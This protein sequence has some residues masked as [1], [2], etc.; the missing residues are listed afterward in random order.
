[1]N[2]RYW[3]SETVKIIKSLFHYSGSIQAK[4]FITFS[5]VLLLSIT[6]ISINIY[7]RF[8]ETIEQNAVTYVSDSIIHAN[9]NFE[10]IRNDIEKISTVIVTN[11]ENI[12]DAITN[13]TDPVTYDGFR[14]SQVMESFL[15]S[16]LAYKTHISRIAVIGLNG[17]IF[18]SGG[19]MLFSSIIQQPWFKTVALSHEKQIMINA[20]E[21][22]SI[23]YSRIIRRNNQPVGIVM[24]DFD[25]DYVR[26]LFDINPVADSLLYI[27]DPLG[28]I[29]F[30]PDH[31]T[32]ASNLQDTELAPF[33]NSTDDNKTN[34][35]QE[36]FNLYGEKHVVVRYIAE[37]TGWMTLGLIP[38]DSLMKKATDIRKQIVQMVAIVFIIL[39]FVSV[40]LSNRMTRGLKHLSL[41]MKKVQRGNL[42][43]RP[44]VRS[45]DEIGDLSKGFNQMMDNIDVLMNQIELREK[46]KRDAELTALQSQI[47]PHFIYN[48]LGTIRNLARLQGVRNIVEITDAFTDLL[49]LTLGHTREMVTIRE[50]LHHLKSYIHIQKYK[51]LD[52]MTFVFQ[53]EDEILHFYTIKLILQPIVENAII[54]ASG[55]ADHPLRITIRIY[56]VSEGI[57][58]EITDNG[59]GMT[60]EQIL[61]A[62]GNLSTQ[63]SFSGIGFKNVNE[64]LQMTYGP[65]YQLNIL[66]E[67]NMYTRVEFTIPIIQNP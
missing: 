19:G 21:N 40:A 59:I 31:I 39:L 60:D 12:I 47:K 33:F 44:V 48:T 1:M 3:K 9:E 16:L 34:L 35:T 29:I 23:S 49:R 8:A 50:E 30:K 45:H 32:N 64:R 46:E 5:I 38:Y 58:F 10:M 53:I 18:S 42:K 51:Y 13:P 36:V 28:N 55:G 22:G 57:K 41:T 66:S 25:K 2:F 15:T 27:V 65:N 61:Q 20:P 63:K 67:K 24:I 62:L 54:H 43:A 11:N 52:R 26:K 7:S 17:K 6:T 56:R 37:S 4:L 14:E